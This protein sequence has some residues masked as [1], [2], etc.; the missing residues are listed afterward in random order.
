MYYSSFLLFFSSKKTDNIFAPKVVSCIV[1]RGGRA[2]KI[3][4]KCSGPRF[5]NKTNR[6]VKKKVMVKFAAITVTEINHSVFFIKK[7]KVK[8]KMN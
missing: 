2:K 1:R 4:R 8:S 3:G 6:A 7:V 5:V